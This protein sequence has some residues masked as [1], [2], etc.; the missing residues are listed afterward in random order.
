MSVIDR[1]ENHFDDDLIIQYGKNSKN[2]KKSKESK[3]KS[4]DTSKSHEESKIDSR[5]SERKKGKGKKNTDKFDESS[6]TS[7]KAS[8]I[9]PNE[10][11]L[12]YNNEAQANRRI[13]YFSDILNSAVNLLI[14]DL[15][16]DDYLEREIRKLSHEK[17]KL[18]GDI[19]FEK[20]EGNPCQEKLQ[21]LEK[22]LEKLTNKINLHDKLTEYKDFSEAKSKCIAVLGDNFNDNLLVGINGHSDRRIVE[23]AINNVLEVIKNSLETIKK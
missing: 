18:E 7:Y 15:K 21:K 14:E 8:N 17:E 3:D 20:N 13:D 6:D 16:K 5:S 22:S 4:E 12:K 9:D 11:I 2:S 23:T 1:N 10:K 19:K